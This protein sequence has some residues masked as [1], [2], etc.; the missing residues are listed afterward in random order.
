MTIAQQY[1]V[2]PWEALLL[3]VK[4]AAGRVAWVDAQ[5]R[6]FTHQNDGDMDAPVVR[7]WLRES[8]NERRLLAQIAKSA[9]DAGV[10]ERLV[11]QVEL[12][13]QVMADTIVAVLDHLQLA[14]EQRQAA[15]EVAQTK[16]LAIGV[17][18]ERLVMAL[19]EPPPHPTD[20]MNTGDGP[21]SD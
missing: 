19:P 15:L 7:H 9:I 4:L 16:L 20:T 5:L 12:E 18:E 14:P 13:G 8:R 10:Q 6:A 3:S 2:S 1:D 21:P 17:S 11:R